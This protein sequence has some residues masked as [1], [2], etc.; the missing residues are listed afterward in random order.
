[1]AKKAG[2]AVAADLADQP[3]PH[4]P[5]KPLDAIVGQARA[6]H[7]LHTALSSGRVHHCWLFSG[8][9]GTGKKTAALAFAAVLL[10]PT[11]QPDLSGRVRPDPESEV[12]KLLARSAHPDLHI[13]RKELAAFSRKDRV[14]NGK[15]TNI[16]VE[17]VREFLIEP[18]QVA[19]SHAGGL[20]NKVFIVEQAELLGGGDPAAQNALLK[21]LEEPPEGTVIILVTASE[22]RL[23]PTVR[24]RSQRVAFTPLTDDDM[25]AW[26]L[27][28]EVGLDPRAVEEALP[29]AEGAPGRLIE[30]VREGDLDWHRQIGPML[31]AAS[32]GSFDP[33]LGQ[34]M[35][36]LA[37][38]WATK[39]AK[40][41]ER[42]SKDVANRAA[43]R[44]MFRL[45]GAH[46]R[47]LIADGRSHRVGIDSAEAVARAEQRLGA[48]TQQSMVME[49]LAADLAE[50]GRRA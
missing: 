4:P 26:A 23:L 35:H 27:S 36:D 7:A 21:T 31:E 2:R 37:N 9:P 50:A 19:S 48:N 45:V 12:A 38:G 16:P 5:P 1:M 49:G 14:R 42:R 6:M 3:P 20:A 8:A 24:S 39:W 30:L 22:N 25:R 29:L 18:A 43:A 46:A 28:A 41:D 17:V 44:R 13:V 32:R 40:V 10:N 11:A 34:T 15:Q 47:S 33:R